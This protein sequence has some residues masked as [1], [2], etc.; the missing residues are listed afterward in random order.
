MGRVRRMEFTLPASVI[1]AQ[2]PELGMGSAEELFK[3]ALGMMY[4]GD[5]F[6]I[7]AVVTESFAGTAYFYVV[8]AVE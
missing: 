1:E 3:A 5:L 4:D 7:E 2:L 8:T 6:H